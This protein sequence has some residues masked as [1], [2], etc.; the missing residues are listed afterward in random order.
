MKTLILS[1]S[2]ATATVS[3]LQAHCG[4]CSID[5]GAESHHGDAHATCH[6]ATLAS[7]FA[8]QKALASDDLANAKT[9][10]S[11]LAESVA[12]S[13]CSIDGE[14]CCA[15]VEGAAESI[16]GASE[17]AVARKAFLGFSE[18]MIEMLDSH[19]SETTAYKMYCP[20]AFNNKGGAWL[21]DNA[22]L[23]NPYFGSMML[24]CGIQ[25]ASYGNDSSEKD[26][27]NK[28]HGH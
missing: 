3:N 12:N 17:I 16:A 7:Y 27:N 28:Q 13:Q 25:Q 6:E 9:S 23:R 24:T 21:Q 15:E 11:E 20:M 5:E 14:D 26:G 22:E 1:L 10:A 8:I 2:I 19:P 18:A 4:T